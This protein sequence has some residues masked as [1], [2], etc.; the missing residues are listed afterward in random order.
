MNARSIHEDNLRLRTMDDAKNTVS[1][2]LRHGRDNRH[3]G[4]D[5]GIEKR[6]LARIG[7]ADDRHKT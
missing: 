1:R 6:A 7:P 3:L 5:K 4:A 2:R